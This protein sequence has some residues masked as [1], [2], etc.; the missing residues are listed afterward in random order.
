MQK[1][2]DQLL[3]ELA[4]LEKTVKVAP[5]I[6]TYA[7]QP[8]SKDIVLYLSFSILIFGLL[9]LAV[10]AWLVIKGREGDQILRVCA[11]PLIIVAAIF[12]V[13][14]GYTSEQIA[15]VMGLLGAIAGY[16]LGSKRTGDSTPSRTGGAE[17]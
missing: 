5:G 13:V 8:W 12:L 3:A 4:E 10:M 1:S 11:L 7:T 9:V 2:L 6:D 15:P 14:T 17:S 16:L